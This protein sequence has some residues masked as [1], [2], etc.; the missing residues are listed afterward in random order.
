MRIE[1]LVLLALAGCPFISDEIYDQRT[2]LDQ[3]GFSWPTDCDDSNAAVHPD[4][5]ERCD[6]VDNNCDERVDEPEATGA[7]AWYADADQDGY[8]TPEGRITSCDQPEGY[9]ANSDDCDD[10]NNLIHPDADEICNDSDDNCDGTADNEPVDADTWYRDSDGDGFGNPDNAQSA[11]KPPAYHVDNNADCDDDDGDINPDAVEICRDFIDND[12][13]ESAGVCDLP[14]SMAAD[15]AFLFLFGNDAGDGSELLNTP[16]LSGDGVGDLVIANHKAGHIWVIVELR[17]GGLESRG[18]QVTAPDSSAL[19][20]AVATGDSNGDGLPQLAVTD[21]K[22][23]VAYVSDSL[24]TPG[25]I[26]RFM[27]SAQ[28]IFAESGVTDM[29]ASIAFGDLY[30][31]GQDIIIVGASNKTGGA[32]GRIYVF[33]HPARPT[34]ADAADARILGETKSDWFGEEIAIADLDSDGIEDLVVGAPRGAGGRGSAYLFTTPPTGDIQAE[35]AQHEIGGSSLGQEI[36]SAIA[37][38]DINSDGYGDFL[39]GA[40]GAGGADGSESGAAFLLYGPVT[41]ANVSDA[42]AKILGS[43]ALARVGEAVSL[44]EDIDGNET[45]DIVISAPGLSQVMVFRHDL[46]GTVSTNDADSVIEGDADSRFGTSLVVYDV[47]E[48][49]FSD[50]LTGAP[51]SEDVD[52]K[53]SVYLF[54]GTGM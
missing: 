9:A 30:K 1:F 6:G 15:D 49:G 25:S 20:A 35:S 32:P 24:D 54:R 40:P 42:D 28:P 31:M 18:F 41:K 19:G 48:D 33:E 50:I 5:V 37:I 38:H 10:S 8:G 47:E 17:T 52:I 53:G 46:A 14:E 12:C 2:D 36:G 13:D 21:R 22:N 51:G 3:D 7:P 27:D 43:T 11:C 4:A 16:D 39:L 29:G 45:P 23:G 44:G 26:S 34:S